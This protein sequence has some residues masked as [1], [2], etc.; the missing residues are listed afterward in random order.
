[1]AAYT[2]TEAKGVRRMLCLGSKKMDDATR[3]TGDI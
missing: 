3:V 2:V 1:M